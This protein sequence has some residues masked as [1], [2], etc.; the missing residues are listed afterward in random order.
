[1]NITLADITESEKICD[2]VEKE[3][4]ARLKGESAPL[5]TNEPLTEYHATL[6]QF[7]AQCRTQLPAMNKMVREMLELLKPVPA[8][9]DNLPGQVDLISKVRRLVERLEA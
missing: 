7:G 9:L 6:M 3:Y 4:Q 1:M 5:M 8:L 2:E